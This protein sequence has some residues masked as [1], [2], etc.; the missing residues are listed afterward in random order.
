MSYLSNQPVSVLIGVSGTQSNTQAAAI[1]S[2]YGEESIRSGAKV[3]FNKGGVD[4]YVSLSEHAVYI[5]NNNP[6][7]S[8]RIGIIELLGTSTSIAAHTTSEVESDF[9]G[10]LT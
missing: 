10:V 9:S 8:L 3:L 7:V 4:F 2:G 5:K 6:N 1:I